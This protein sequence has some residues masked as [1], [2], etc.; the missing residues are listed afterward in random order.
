[1]VIV[2]N[3]ARDS[4][5]KTKALFSKCFVE[6][7]SHLLTVFSIN[8][9]AE[10]RSAK[11][12][13]KTCKYDEY[14]SIFCRIQFYVHSNIGDGWVTR[15]VM[16]NVQLMFGENSCIIS[17]VEKLRARRNLETSPARALELAATQLQVNGRANAK[18]LII[19]AH[20]GFSTDL[21]AETI[22]A[23]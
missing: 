20:N 5:K 6:F 4:D 23:R 9:D 18:K 17:E 22:E 2:A 21:I 8:Y 12:S 11:T 10:E 13:E 7:F 1:M 16:G 14:D 19:L 15:D 3:F